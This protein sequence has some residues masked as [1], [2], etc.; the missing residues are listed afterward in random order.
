MSGNTI[1]QSLVWGGGGRCGTNW[2]LEVV[3]IATLCGFDENDRFFTTVCVMEIEPSR[4]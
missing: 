3:E 2:P 1:F 4:Y